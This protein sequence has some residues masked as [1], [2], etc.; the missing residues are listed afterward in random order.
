M[1]AHE[2]IFS[3]GETEHWIAEQMDRRFH[4]VVDATALLCLRQASDMLEEVWS[5]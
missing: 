1:V 4:K 2:M 5:H 3:E